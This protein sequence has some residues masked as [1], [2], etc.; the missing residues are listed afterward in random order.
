MKRD[1]QRRGRSVAEGIPIIHTRSPTPVLND[2]SFSSWENQAVHPSPGACNHLA[3]P[4]VNVTAKY[5]TPVERDYIECE[6]ADDY[7]NGD[8]CAYGGFQTRS[9]ASD[10]HSQTQPN[11]DAFSS[12]LYQACGDG[13]QHDQ[14]F[15]SDE[16]STSNH[17]N[18]HSQMNLDFSYLS[19]FNQGEALGF[20]QQGTSRLVLSLLVCTIVY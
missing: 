1:S 12:Q 15:Y 10:S 14:P 4:Q 2:P 16:A 13:S 6:M 3:L 7:G 5:D 20:S 19:D 17:A 18:Y 8:G 11:L 9:T